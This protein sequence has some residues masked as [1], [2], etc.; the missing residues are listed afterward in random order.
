MK[1]QS[2]FLSLFFL[3]VTSLPSPLTAADFQSTLRA[4]F[5]QLLEGLDKNLEID[6]KVDFNS[7][8]LPGSLRAWHP[9]QPERVVSLNFVW[10]TLFEKGPNPLRLL[11]D[12]TASSGRS[13]SLRNRT[14][15]F[16][17]G[18]VP[19]G[20]SAQADE[21]TFL[22]YSKWNSYSSFV[23]DAISHFFYQEIQA[24]VNHKAFSE[25]VP[26]ISPPVR[27]LESDAAYIADTW[28]YQAT[29]LIGALTALY[30]AYPF[31][32]VEEPARVPTVVQSL[33]TVTAGLLIV[34][35]PAL[36]SSLEK[37]FNFSLNPFQI[38]RYLRQQAER[39]KKEDRFNRKMSAFLTPVLIG[40]TEVS[41]VFGFP[42]EDE[43]P[44]WV[45]VPPDYGNRTFNAVKDAIVHTLDRAKAESEVHIPVAVANPLLDL[46]TA[47]A[48][49]QGIEDFNK[50]HPEGTGTKK[51]KIVF[52]RENV[53]TISSSEREKLGRYQAI[54][55]RGSYQDFTP[56][57]LTCLKLIES[58]F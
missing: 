21:T 45:W 24:L 30:G 44:L 7:D 49:Y 23:T 31:F 54:L 12:I 37:H 57:H 2:L 42:Q 58:Q 52:S 14:R 26:T 32:V 41:L 55:T 40:T 6:F 51:I 11:D 56:A 25:N 16:F 47:Y 3:L 27:F 18:T 1:I 17:G 36:H 46:R 20:L 10:Q 38:R 19:A 50:L 9:L 8:G 43:N 34:A 35:F 4:S 28:F 33:A 39:R 5:L 29:T 53:G 13:L 22:I 15:E 48:I